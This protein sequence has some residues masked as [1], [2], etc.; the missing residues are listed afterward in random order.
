M[1]NGHFTSVHTGRAADRSLAALSAGLGGTSAKYPAIA[2][3]S[4]AANA[5]AHPADFVTPPPTASRW[6][7]GSTRALLHE[8]ARLR[9]L[10]PDRIG[11]LRERDGRGVVRAR[12]RGIAGLFRGGG[13]AELGVQPMRL[14]VQRR[15]V[16]GER[17]LGH[18]ALEQHGAV[19]L[20]R[21]R[22]HARRDRM[23]VGF[24]LGIGGGAHGLERVL[25]LALRIKH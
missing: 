9:D 20:A 15:L 12:L 7:A 24:V 21:R 1:G 11:V 25:V 18:A 2:A 5:S 17:L 8:R 14:L 6:L 16:C 3:A 13:G 19:E 22:R 4:P 23:L 10:R